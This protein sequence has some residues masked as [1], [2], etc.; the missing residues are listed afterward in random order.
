MCEQDYM[1]IEHDIWT[2]RFYNFIFAASSSLNFIQCLDLLLLLLRIFPLS[3]SENFFFIWQ[4]IS[5]WVEI[6]QLSGF[7]F[8]FGFSNPKKCSLIVIL[9]TFNWYS[10]ESNN[11]LWDISVDLE[12]F[13]QCSF[14]SFSLKQKKKNVEEKSR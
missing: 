5:F 4:G 9:L 8:K 6:G 2:C 7:R 1:W 13:Q 11:K 14:F 10:D 3:K 12:K